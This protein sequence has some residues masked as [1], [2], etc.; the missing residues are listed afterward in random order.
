MVSSEESEFEELDDE[1]SE[2]EL[3]GIDIL[4][5]YILIVIIKFSLS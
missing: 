2:R 5:Y 4:N 3:R 1:E